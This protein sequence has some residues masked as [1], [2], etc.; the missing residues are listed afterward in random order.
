[1]THSRNRRFSASPAILVKDKDGNI[2]FGTPADFVR[3]ERRRE[4]MAALQRGDRETYERLVWGK[5]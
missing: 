4:G 1:M 2:K 5:K 3:A